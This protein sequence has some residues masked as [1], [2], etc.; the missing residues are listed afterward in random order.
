MRGEA[1]IC[2]CC[3]GCHS[4][5]RTDVG[6]V[7][8]SRKASSSTASALVHPT[9]RTPS[10]KPRTAHSSPISHHRHKPS[11][12]SASLSPL[13]P[14]VFSPR[15]AACLPSCSSFR[16]PRAR[17]PAP[18]PTAPLRLP[19]LSPVRLTL[20]SPTDPPTSPSDRVSRRPSQ[21]GGLRSGTAR[22]RARGYHGPAPSRPA[23]ALDP[24][25]RR[26]P[27]LPSSCSV[28]AHALIAVRPPLAVP[29]RCAHANPLIF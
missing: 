20:P 2:V 23:C 5:N 27:P 26:A 17:L 24:V 16:R 7:P 10:S 22:E 8:D 29:Y 1:C 13:R 11:F 3:D 14:R 4:S 19:L 25:S 9:P 18:F 15:P 6:P 21:G 12:P 28:R